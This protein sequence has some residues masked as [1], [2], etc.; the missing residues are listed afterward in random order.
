ME[1]YC[2][3]TYEKLEKYYD[4]EVIRSRDIVNRCINNDSLEN[5]KI[6]DHSILTWTQCLKTEFRKDHT[7]NGKS[8]SYKKYDFSSIPTDFMMDIDTQR[9]DNPV[10]E[11]EAHQD[12]LQRLDFIYDRFCQG[13]KSQMDFHLNY[14]TITLNGNSNKKRR[15]KKSWWTEELSKLCNDMCIRE[16][17]WLKCNTN[18]NTQLKQLFVNKRKLFD[19]AFQRQFE[20]NV[21][22]DQDEADN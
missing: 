7:T 21:S 13:V 4:F 6:P 1:D 20:W 8:C 3:V 22:S 9:T 5:H 17:R 19:R 2:L 16:K 10:H 18:D 14:N 11:M 12:E 15:T